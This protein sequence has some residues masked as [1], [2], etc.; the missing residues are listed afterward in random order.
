MSGNNNKNVAR[1]PMSTSSSSKTTTSASSSELYMNNKKRSSKKKQGGSKGFGGA[2]R[3]LQK[4]AFAYA[5]TVTPG[6]QSPQRVVVDESI[7]KPDYT[8]DGIVSEQKTVC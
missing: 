2:L 6:N 1:I 3:S 5:G 8:L 7:M 4:N